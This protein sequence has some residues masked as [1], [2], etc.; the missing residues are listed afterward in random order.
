MSSVAFSQ[1]GNDTLL[2]KDNVMI[3]LPTV[4][5]N[6]GFNH[7][8]ADVSLS[9]DG[10]TPFRQ[11]G[12]QLSITQQV[13][14]FLNATL[15]LYTGTVYGE[16]QRNLTNINFRT[17]I[18][19]QRLNLEYNFYPLLKPDASGRQLLRPYLGI[20]VG[21]MFFRNKG[22]LLDESNNVYN[23][24][25]DGL[26]YAEIEG[27]V[28]QSEATLLTRDFEYETDLRDANLDGLRKYPQTAFTLPINAGIRFQV[29]KNVGLNAAFT[30]ALNFTDMIDNV[31]ETGLGDRSGTSGND[32]QLYG[33]IG[34]TVFL[35]STKPSAKPAKKN[36]DL[37]AASQ[38][39]DGIDKTKFDNSESEA[40][41]NEATVSEGEETVVS[42]IVKKG[43]AYNAQL[44]LDQQRIEALAQ[45]QAATELSLQSITA[46]K[47]E[48]E[49]SSKLTNSTKQNILSVIEKEAEGLKRLQQSNSSA[50]ENIQVEE[51]GSES[52][53]L[54]LANQKVSTQ[55]KEATSSQMELL[56]SI[57][58][59]LGKAKTTK[60]GLSVASQLT[61]SLK[62][63]KSLFEEIEKEAF[64]ASV[65]NRLSNL[66][67]KIS[68]YEFARDAEYVTEEEQSTLQSVRTKLEKEIAS[69][70]DLGQLNVS[71]SN[72]MKIQLS[73]ETVALQQLI[74]NNENVSIGSSNEANTNQS[75]GNNEQSTDAQHTVSELN[76]S[77]ESTVESASVNKPK[78]TPTIEE[79]ENTP[80]K[81]SGGFH[82]ADVNENGWISPD[83]VLHFIDLLFEGESVRT[84]GDIQNLIDYYFDQE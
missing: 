77:E 78:R 55:I 62:Y 72:K 53:Q 15:D 38:T 22:D 58:G 35:G 2:A 60:D 46:I 74:S 73:G 42:Q 71:V 83:E 84:V 11:L 23:Y 27:T 44:E 19:S 51:T 7:L 33:S 52:G 80:E 66:E 43:L 75:S 45:S 63:S 56:K 26:I 48:L 49:S 21:A 18:F 40:L 3:P 30:Y 14:K 31:G 79:I 54:A 4:S 32:N 76:S 47:T 20:G 64:K 82:W 8:M 13:A 41:Q 28:S 70:E 24:W 1:N 16:E 36:E 81:V 37:L 9:S 12:Y 10:P 50:S 6:V 39:S 69:M 61:E 5:I 34:L 68:L 67:D 29:S 57:E 65:A 17:S 25:S 59:N